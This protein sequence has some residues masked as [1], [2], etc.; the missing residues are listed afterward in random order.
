[1]HEIS[2]ENILKLHAASFK[3][4]LRDF[5]FDVERLFLEGRFHNPGSGA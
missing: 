5:M 4:D 1:L 2:I 3:I